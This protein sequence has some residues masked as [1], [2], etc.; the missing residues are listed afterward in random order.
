MATSASSAASAR[1][2]ARGVAS[3]PES[4]LPSSAETPRNPASS[5]SSVLCT[6]EAAI[7]AFSNVLERVPTHVAAYKA[8]A[9]TLLASGRIDAWFANFERFERHCPNHIALAAH[10]LEVCAYRADFAKLAHYLDN[11][12]SERFPEG[13]PEEVLDALQQILYL[14]HFFVVFH[15]ARFVHER[16]MDISNFYL[17]VPWAMLGFVLMLP[18]GYLSFRFIERPFL[19]HRK[20]YV[21]TKASPAD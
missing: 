1:A 4:S 19:R 21:E 14:L 2:I 16:V 20:R 11:L 6:S 17:A 5:R 18:I 10:A 8:L 9:E 15:A 12:R 13:E 3:T 7:A